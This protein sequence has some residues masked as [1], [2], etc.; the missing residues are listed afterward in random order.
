MGRR[1][2]KTIANPSERPGT[3]ARKTAKGTELKNANDNSDLSEHPV[4]GWIASYIGLFSYCISTGARE[5]SDENQ[6][7]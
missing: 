2:R 6:S 4:I 1:G 7:R 5:N 3:A